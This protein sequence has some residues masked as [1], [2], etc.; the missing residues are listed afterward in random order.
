MAWLKRAVVAG[1]KNAANLKQDRDLDALRGR[2]DF[3][4][5]MTE[6]EGV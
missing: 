6:V 2:A 1:Y 4:K 3:R 5:L